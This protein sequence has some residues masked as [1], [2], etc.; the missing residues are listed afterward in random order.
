MQSELAAIVL[1]SLALQPKSSLGHFILEASRR[2]TMTHTHTHTHARA[3]TDAY[4]V[5]LTSDQ[6]VTEATT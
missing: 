1:F 4:M 6:F 3:Q 5:G 2:P